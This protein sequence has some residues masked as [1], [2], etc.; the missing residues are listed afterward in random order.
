[1]WHETGSNA[2]P[3]RR[4]MSIYN[5]SIITVHDSDMY[6]HHLE[7]KFGKSLNWIGKKSIWFVVFVVVVEFRTK[8]PSS[9]TYCHTMEIRSTNE[10]RSFLSDFLYLSFDFSPP[11]LVLYKVSLVNFWKLLQRTTIPIFSPNIVGSTRNF[12]DNDKAE[13]KKN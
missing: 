13:Q 7:W 11:G 2:F 9:S 10:N 12:I 5:I 3:A 1:M 6:S 8:R 4:K